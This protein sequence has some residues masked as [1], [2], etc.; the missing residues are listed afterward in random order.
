MNYRIV[1]DA[2]HGGEDPGAISGSLKEKDFTLKAAN[3]MYNRFRELGVPVTITRDTDR[4]LS[5]TERLNTMRSLGTDPNVII[6]SNHINAGN[7]EGAEVVYPL[8]TNERLARMILESIGREGQIMR[9]YYQ[10]RLPED[11]SKDYYYIMRETPNTTSLLLEYGFID[12]KNDQVKLQNYLLNYVEAVVRAVM[13]YIGLP[14]IAPGGTIDNTYTVKRGDTLYSIARQY[15]TTVDRIKALNNLTSNNLSVGQVLILDEEVDIKPDIENGEAYTVQPG[16]TLYKIANR[17]NTN[18]TDIIE[19]N[20]LNSTILTVGQQ[21]L[22][23]NQSLDETN[24]YVVKA[25][26]YLNKIANQFGV[27]VDDIISANN[28]NNTVLQ[29]GQ[30]LTIPTGIEKED[31][32][33][34]IEANTYQVE[35]G[36]TLY[37]IAKNFNTTVDEIKRLNNLTSNTLSIGQILNINNSI[38]EPNTQIP[39]T[40]TYTVQRGDSLWLIANKLNTTVDEIKRLNNLSTNLLQIGQVLLIPE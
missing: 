23:P 6:L 13:S 20:N 7:G 3:Y 9:K 16:D 14:Y 8:R 21:I 38:N 25:G 27:T 1:V 24:T 30:V 29:I 22:I 15:N 39:S 17:F 37:Q 26:D 40:Q 34:P 19:L 36:D 32:S 31:P 18:I 2:G 5:R 33:I 4:T 28:L 35:P 12:N 10:R 11:P